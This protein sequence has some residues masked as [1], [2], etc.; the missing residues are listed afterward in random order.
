[1]SSLDDKLKKL[2]SLSEEMK[3]LYTEVFQDIGEEMLE[4]RTLKELI[5]KCYYCDSISGTLS[6]TSYGFEHPEDIKR[7]EELLNEQ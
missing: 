1:M 5:N 6:K 2:T 3:E 4:L 7:I